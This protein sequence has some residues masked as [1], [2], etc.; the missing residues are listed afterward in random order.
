MEQILSLVADLSTAEKVELISQITQHLKKELKTG[1]VGKAIKASKKDP[2]APKKKTHVNTRAWF[3]FVAHLKATQP[4][5]FVDCSKAPEYL[6]VCKTVKE[7]DME[8]YEQFKA[9]FIAR[10]AEEAASAADAESSAD[11]AAE[12]SDSEG[13]EEAKPAAKPAAAKPAAKSAAERLA[14]MKAAA[15]AKAAAKSTEKAVKPAAEK[16]AEKEKPAKTEKKEKKQV[17]KAAEKPAEKPAVVEEEDDKM[18]KKTI[19]GEDYWLDTEN[20][21]LW[22]VDPDGTGYGPWVG[23]YQAD[24]EEEPIRYTD[25]PTDE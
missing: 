13:E 19:N 8:A 10:D 23:Y 1:K 24:N 15:A 25:S 20:N 14:E 9:D 18:P 6:A 3:A 22:K 11:S 12:S 4:D 7:G 17:K 2:S 16:P 5:L 21:G